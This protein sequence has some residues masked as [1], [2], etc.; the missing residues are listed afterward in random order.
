MQHHSKMAFLE[1]HGGVG[2]SEGTLKYPFA[3]QNDWIFI[4][5]KD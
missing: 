4:G 1:P 2:L 3:W 5:H